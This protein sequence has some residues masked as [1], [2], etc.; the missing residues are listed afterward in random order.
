M[1]VLD[2]FMWNIGL[3]SFYIVI[4]LLTLHALNLITLFLELFCTLVH[5][6]FRNYF[7]FFYRS[8]LLYLKAVYIANSIVG[9]VITLNGA[10]KKTMKGLIK[11]LRHRK[12]RAI[13][14]TNLF[15][16]L[17]APILFSPSVLIYFRW[18]EIN[19][20]QCR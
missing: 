11:R 19:S 1:L 16:M 13:N 3:F 12:L 14:K 17:G 10:I 7:I 4:A 15:Q 8:F 5:G 20:L 6:T 2:T 9:R 18:Y